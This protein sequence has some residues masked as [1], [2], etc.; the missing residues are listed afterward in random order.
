MR[1]HLAFAGFNDL[2][3]NLVRR[4]A[5]AAD[6]S[7]AGIVAGEIPPQW[8]GSPDEPILYPGCGALFEEADPDLLLVAEEDIDLSVIP[9][10]CQ[11]ISVGEGTPAESMLESLIMESSVK[12]AL[13]KE[14]REIASLISNIS[15]IEAYTDPQPKLGQLVDRAMA[16]SDS[17]IGIVLLPG[18]V[19]DELGVFLARGDGADRM[20]G[21][22]L[23]VTG[24]LCGKSYDAGRPLQGDINEGYEETR[25]LDSLNLRGLY[26]VPMR[27]EGRITGILA[28]GKKDEH[29]FDSLRMSLL[30]I[31]ADQAGLAMQISYLYSEL[32][33]NVVMDS[34]SGLYNQH[35]LHQRMSEEVNRARRYSLNVCLVAMEIDGFVA[36][37]E[38]NG[39][40]MGDLIL[41]D[42]GN[43]IKR[44]TRE[45]DT[46]AR[47]GDN[48]FAVLLP[49]TR[50]LGSM[51]LAER[52]RKVVQEYP[53]PSR[54]RKEVERLT[55][56]AGISSFPASADNEGELMEKALCAL[57]EAQDSGPN[58]IR[59][60]SEE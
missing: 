3:A 19:L 10:E 11:V 51:R 40:S 7:V 5:D 39:R 4:M 31:I 38:R 37:V 50:R 22:K 47:C 48:R 23:S 46:G 58:N 9:G 35:Y 44:N 49:E 15:V 26:A 20:I 28:L 43:I 54:E 55:I 52:I 25:Y 34:A 8:P 36:Y 60:Y 18:N 32:E 21:K 6:L 1:V 2:C 17:D 30:S 12:K 13:E 45:V 27:A 14:I 29:A 59:L 57:V 56:C 24:S 41:S 53:F 42:V 33:A 16:I